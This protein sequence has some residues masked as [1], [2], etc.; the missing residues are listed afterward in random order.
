MKNLMLGHVRREIFQ[1]FIN[2]DT[3]SSDARL[4]AALIWVNRYVITIVH[5]LRL[6]LVM[7]VVKS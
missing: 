2:G 4:T 3:Q 7:C 6:R 5:N 1:Y